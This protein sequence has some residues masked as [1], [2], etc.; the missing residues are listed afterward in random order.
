MI[1]RPL[2]GAWVCLTFATLA[3][4]LTGC[5]Q[6][7]PAPPPNSQPSAGSPKEKTTFTP[8][9]CLEL[10]RL[11]NLAVGA[12]ENERLNE[13][14]THLAAILA[15]DPQNHLAQRNM[16]VARLLGLQSGITTVEQAEA[17]MEALVMGDPGGLDYW[18]MGRMRLLI[19][20]KLTEPA[21]QAAV[22]TSALDAMRKAQLLTPGRPAIPWEVFEATRYGTPDQQRIARST[23]SEAASMAPDN[24]FLLT[25]RMLQQADDH[26]TT[27]TESLR[28]LQL[29]AGPL[30]EGVQRRARVDLQ[31]LIDAA[32]AGV[33]TQQWAQVTGRIR[34]ITAVLRPE[35]RAQSDR[36]QLSP[37]P[38]EFVLHDFSPPLCEDQQP[39]SSP[40]QMITFQSQPF[41]ASETVGAI[42]DIEIADWN[43]DGVPEL[44]LL[45]NQAL[46]IWSRQQLSAPWE[47]TLSLPVSAAF[48]GIVSVDFDRDAIKATT[49]PT[50]GV[51]QDA[52]ADLVLFGPDGVAVY[53]NELPEAGSRAFVL[54]EQTA[55][56]SEVRN[57]TTL[58]PGDFDHDGDL[59]LA[60]W[61]VTGMQ[62]WSQTGGLEF[63]NLTDRVQS[64]SASPMQARLIAVD[65]DRDVDLDIVALGENHFGLY[66]NLR[67]GEF[68][69]QPFEREFQELSQAATAS[70]A[71]LDGNV[72]WDLL[73]SGPR[74]AQTMFTQT[75]AAQSVSFLS[76][77]T[78]FDDEVSHHSVGDWNNDGWQDVL[79]AD[80]QGIQ[81]FASQQG[82]LWTALPTRPDA[83]FVPQRLKTADLDQDG[84]LDVVAYDGKNIAVLKNT[85]EAASGWLAV[86]VRGD[87]DPQS[88]RVN[89][90][91]IGSLLE[92]RTGEHYQ[93]Q[94]IT[95]QVTHFGLGDAEQADTLRVLWTNGVPQ[96]TLQPTRNQAVC[97]RLAL[98]GSCPY[99]YTWNGDQFAFYTDLLWAAPLGLQFAEG[100]LAPS[101]PWEYLLVSGDTLKENQGSYDIRVT[102]ELWEAAYFD[103]IELLAIDHPAEVEVFS[104]EKVGPPDI[105][106]MQ[107][108]TVKHRRHPVTA[109]DQ[110][111]R[112]VRELLQEIDDRYVKAFDVEYRQGLTEP[113][114]LELDLGKLDHPQRITLFLTGWI[115]PTDTS[116]N[117]ALS[118]DPGLDGPRPPSLSVPDA[119]G[120]WQIV[121]PFMGFPGGKTKTIAIDLSDAFLT[122]DYRVRIETTHEIYWD[123]AFFTVDET[124]AEVRVTPLKLAAADLHYRGFSEAIPPREHAP[125]RYAYQYVSTSPKWPP[126]LGKFTRYGEVR[127]LLTTTD[128]RLVVL[129]SGDEISLKFEVPDEPLPAGWRRDF[130]LHNVGWDKDADLHTVYGQTVEPLP[131]QAM[132]GYPYREETGPTETPVYRDYLRQYQTRDAQ[133]LN[134]WQLRNSTAGKFPTSTP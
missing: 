24:L 89:Q 126:M 88:G 47:Q 10:A 41:P 3:L 54:V 64:P 124:P 68:R 14:E 127:E 103:Q 17:A 74:G 40:P 65:W 38:L 27:L 59:D 31:E 69:W 131:Y 70:V 122:E 21:A 107:V 44:W 77:R 84:R 133:S 57:V 43:L 28:H 75:I 8:Q 53:R 52:D 112:D 83:G 56:L 67:H 6:N 48:T 49:A 98:K 85:T 4:G 45:G 13:A 99:L 39:V 82:Q 93:A 102:E 18:L 129:G 66:E 105:A 26:D 92:V 60:L 22:M 87:E 114:A 2:P 101:R 46:E 9:Q 116:L 97:E 132:P 95:G 7:P 32:A 104:N 5:P 25:E 34:T 117:V 123:A 109:R 73:L 15:I 63:A 23:L 81:A 128:D 33:A 76:V 78:V 71:E 113:H 119:Q 12:L 94:V 58:I 134:Y 86:R 108:H 130:F 100:V 90:Y 11:R 111:G 121:R 80:S 20:E 55:G 120:N 19:A 62:L 30:R 115:Y 79:I 61:T 96:V 50:P 51:C 1:S 91:G 37:H 125:E 35:D 110:R 36:R 42:H 106:A 29:I 72:S 16:A 118:Q